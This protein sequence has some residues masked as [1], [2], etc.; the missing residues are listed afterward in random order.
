MV[1]SAIFSKKGPKW[2]FSK[3]F[4]RD[5]LHTHKKRVS[6]ALFSKHRFKRDFLQGRSQDRFFSKQGSNFNFSKNGPSG[7]PPKRDLKYDFLKAGF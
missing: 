6:S 4:K 3:G 7:F 5:F 2:I 1:L